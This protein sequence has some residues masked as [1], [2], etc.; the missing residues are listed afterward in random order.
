MRN[1]SQDKKPPG[2]P[3][4]Y[5]DQDDAMSNYSVRLPARLARVARRQGAGSLSEGIRL[6]IEEKEVRRL[7]GIDD[8]VN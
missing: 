6:A 8:S 3:R 2:R 5:R 1:D 4:V 7:T